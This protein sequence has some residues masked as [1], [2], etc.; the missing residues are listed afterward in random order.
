[1]NKICH[2]VYLKSCETDQ[3]SLS[4]LRNSV[5]FAKP[6]ALEAALGIGDAPPPHP[7][8]KEGT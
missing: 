1:M 2:I 5:R 7:Q 3:R 6:V 8:P 4:H